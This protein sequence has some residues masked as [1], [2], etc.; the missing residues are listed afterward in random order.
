M[1]IRIN[2]LS[3][4]DK[5]PAQG[6]GSA[7]LEQKDLMSS[8]KKYEIEINSHK[9]NFD[10]YHIHSVHFRYFTRMN[11]K[12]INVVSVHF[13]P[14]DNQDTVKLIWPANKIFDWYV[15]QFY[16][17]A[18]ELVIVNPHFKSSLMKLG[19]A[20]DRITY[21]PNY[22][23]KEYFHELDS[24]DELKDKY[25]LPKDKF[26]VL[27]VGQ[28]QKKKAFHEFIEV[29]KSNPDKYFVWV[30]DFTFGRITVGYKEYKKLLKNAPTNFKHISLL[31]KEEMNEI[32]NTCSVFFLPSYKEFFPMVILEAAS[33]G[34]PILLRD[35]SLYT[36]ILFDKFAKG[37]DVE[38][39]SKEIDR[40]SKDSSY[41]QKRKE[42][43]KFISSFYDKEKMLEAWEDFYQKIYNKHHHK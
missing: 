8:S 18:D 23:S 36:P 24:V 11:K 10:I 6:V 15:N 19:I 41:Y 38:E 20:E 5:V 14:S 3:R 17:K 2:N 12:H 21:I 1:P 40:L 42:D 34:K 29:C 43:A 13:I 39:F 22:V 30:G 37:K 33:V 28:I 35:L 9:G 4:A 27:G 16:K 7:Y 32:Y 26:I 31:N 25:G